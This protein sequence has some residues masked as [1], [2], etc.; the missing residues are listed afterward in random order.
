MN[1]EL[2]II[3][4]GPA[5]S[6]AAVY[7]ARKKIHTLFLTGSFIGQ[8]SVSFEIQNWIGEI[9]IS[10][11]ELDKKLQ[12]H[13]AYY[14]SQD[15][16]VQKGEFV[17]KIDK[18]ET[19]F[20]VT[21]TKGTYTTKTVLITTGRS[22]RKLTIKGADIYDNKGVTYCAS[23]DAPLFGGADVAV[24]GG[25]NAAFESAAQLSAH[26][27][28]VTLI[29]RADSFRAEPITIEK[30]LAMPNVRAVKNTEL[31]EVKGDKFVTN[32]VY[33][34]KNTNE[35]V[36]LPV[37]GIFVEI[38]AV[39]A[40]DFVR[41]GLVTLDKNDSIKID[42][43]TNKTETPGIWAAGD[44]TNILYAQNNIAVGH[45]V[46]AIEDLFRYLRA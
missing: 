31:I 1:F 37:T 26:A 23:C 8:S 27:R 12:D 43:W 38:G 35:T 16:V 10:G 33:L 25:G 22:R 46:N 34:D 42:P 2:I 21:T 15:L 29:Q 13:V 45:A 11:N 40:V 9:K 7:A 17:T 3:G 14:A 36:D 19:G 39:P 24:I 44:C 6:A 18:S 32:L 28:S 4:G 20:T 30:V 5:G 41:H